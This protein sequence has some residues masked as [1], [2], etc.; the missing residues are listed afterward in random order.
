V[1]VVVDESRRG[2][3]Y[4]L[5]AALLRPGELA[6]TRTL[7]RG[8]R[9]PGERK[10]H[11]KHERDTI[12]KDIAAAL[13]SAELRTRVYLGHGRAEAV[14]ERCL[15]RLV[16]DLSGAGMRRLVLDSRGHGGDQSDRRIIHSALTVSGVE[17]AAVS[18]EHFRSHG[19]PAA[20]GAAELAR[21]WKA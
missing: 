13:V 11:F 3:L 4:L 15:R 17:L 6:S 2:S 18:Y 21:S 7:M 14:R 20:N 12:Q 16:A 5:A 1:H 8:L 10:L 9:V 19:E